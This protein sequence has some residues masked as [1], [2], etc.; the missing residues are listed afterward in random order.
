MS[1]PQL[2]TLAVG[3]G[4]SARRI[5]YLQHPGEG[6]GLLWMQGLK[7]DMVST[8]ASALQD[9]AGENGVALTRFDYSGHGQSEGRFEDGTIGRWLEDSD[10]VFRQLTSGPQIVIGSSMGGY[11]ALLLLRKLLAEAPAEAKRLAAMILIAPAWDMTEELMWKAFPPA[12]REEIERDGRWLRPS[13]YGDPYPI[14]RALIEDGRTHLLARRPWAPGRPIIIL[15]GTDD[16]DVPLAHVRELTGFLT[17]DGVELIEIAGGD[18][19]LSRPEDIAL[20]L[21]KVESLCLLNIG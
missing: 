11:L 17:G 20:M 12:T 7:S 19:R 13:E 5:A 16:P 10:A 15:Q 3:R 18:H 6:P 14:T 4:A 8:K 9:W 21:A 2:Q 1:E